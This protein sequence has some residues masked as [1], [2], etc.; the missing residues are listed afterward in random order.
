MV[1]PLPGVSR[2]AQRR[3]PASGWYEPLDWVLVRAPL[4]PVECWLELADRDAAESLAREPA[5]RRALAVAS[6]SLFARLEH[7]PA[8]ASAARRRRQGILRYLIRMSTRCTPYGLNASV[9]LAEWGERTDLALAE[10]EVVRARLDMGLLDAFVGGLERRL[11]VVRELRLHAHPAVTVRAGR[12][13]LPERFSS[14]EGAFEVSVR[15]TRPVVSAL[16]LCERAPAAFAAVAGALGTEFPQAGRARIEELIHALVREGLL[17]TELRPPLTRGEPARH[18]LEVLTRITAAHED[19]DRLAAA[20]AACAHWESEPGAEG[21]A[22]VLGAAHAV[23]PP[24][25]E[26]PAVR[27]DMRRRLAGERIARAVGEEAARAAELLCR[28]SPLR[29]GQP[30]LNAY[31][32][33]FA[34]RYAPHTEVGL[35]ELVDPEVG[36]GHVDLR[37]DTA[38]STPLDDEARRCQRRLLALAAWALREERVAVELDPQTIAELGGDDDVEL[39]EPTMELSVFVAAASRAA[40]DAGD[41]QVV[42]SPL[43]GSHAA[44]R[45]IGR[46][47]HLFDGPGERAVRAA[48]QRQEEGGGDRVWAELV[49][50]PERPWLSNVMIRPGTRRHEI[51]VGAA[52]GVAADRVIPLDELV[53]GV[54]DDSF[55]LRWPRGGRYVE[56]CEGHMLNPKAAPA[57]ATFLALLRNAGRPVVTHFTWGGARDLPRLPRVTSGRV[58]LSPATWRPPFG[59]GDLDA[60]QT[61]RFAAALRSWRTQ[62]R[63]P[64]R[65]FAAQ[66]D[67]RLLL[68]LDAPDQVELLRRLVARGDVDVALQEALPGPDSAWLPGPGGSFLAE[69]CVPLGRRAAS[70]DGRRAGPPAGLA[71][72]PRSARHRPPGSDWLYAKLYAG[73]RAAD[74]LIGDAIG[75]FAGDARSAGLAEDWFFVRYRDPRPHVRVRLRGDPATLARE[76]APKLEDWASELIERGLCQALVLDTYERELERYGGEQGMAIA[77]RIFGVDSRAAA[78]LVALDLAGGIAAD[79]EQLCVLTV[80]RLL[81]GLGLDPAARLAWCRA[82]GSVRHEVADDW[83]ELKEPLRALLGGQTAGGDTVAALLDAFETGVRAP[84]DRLAALRRGG[85][86]QWP[87]ADELTA[88][89]VHM[90]CNRLL[91]LDRGAERRVLGLLLRTLESLWRAPVR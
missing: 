21:F 28:L 49:Y 42:V 74:E 61:E 16:R 76:L 31:R 68:D 53:V 57:I 75:P 73:G 22:A 36:L 84:A 52:P 90:H 78:E 87:G 89:F 39:P 77:E 91:G 18:V 17:L 48:T 3:C 45:L 33:R 23:A 34:E 69:L 35:V 37:E 60:G 11:D 40:L 66:G 30:S 4:L 32:D 15:A 7:E 56:V 85:A 26:V 1:A 20:L 43:L 6:P 64:R 47:A 5:V 71:A 46:F 29:T 27:V 54:R 25:A 8:G 79:R 38:G 10:E 51:A 24:P 88:G 70:G 83:R 67:H 19:R 86:I 82:R 58:V 59:D 65:V 14:D 50:G 41:F 44:G 55:Y 12:A 62:W 80:D 9:S 63:L 81:E 13:F 2:P 72:Q